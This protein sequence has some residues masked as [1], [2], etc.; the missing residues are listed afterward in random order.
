MEKGK[1]ISNLPF[2]AS[3]VQAELAVPCG[4]ELGESPVWDSLNSSLLWIDIAGKALFRWTPSLSSSSSSSCTTTHLHER[5]GSIALCDD[6]GLLIALEHGPALLP[7]GQPLSGLIRIAQFEPS[8]PSSRMNDGRVDRQG[9][10]VVGGYNEDG[11]PSPPLSNIYR[12]D[13]YSLEME[14]VRDWEMF[15]NV[16]ERGGRCR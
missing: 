15:P 10:F 16:G 4:S 3:V 9:R 2:V 5:P 6:G 1:G 8:L 7:P 11:F 13:P 12:I 14:T